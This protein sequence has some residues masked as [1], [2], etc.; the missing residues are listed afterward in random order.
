[1]LDALALTGVL[2]A[3]AEDVTR[4]EERAAF[5]ERFPSGS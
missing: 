5:D 3:C 1:M 4:L 2:H